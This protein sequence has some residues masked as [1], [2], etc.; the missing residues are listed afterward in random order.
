MSFKANPLSFFG[1]LSYTGHLLF[2]PGVALVY[3]FGVK[4]YL[5]KRAA[6]SEKQQWES[7]PKLRK[8]DPDLFNP[9][10]PIPY[11]NNAE[12]TYVFAHIRM[13]KYINENHINPQD[14]VWKNYH[15]S[16]DHNN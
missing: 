7:M 2:Y 3:L 15:N 16:Y 13:H 6:D 12:L 9:F 14:Y 8:I 11:H 5:A 1:R 10:T 4:P